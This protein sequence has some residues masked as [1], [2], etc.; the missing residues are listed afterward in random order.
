MDLVNILLVEDLL[1]SDFLS[2]RANP[3]VLVALIVMFTLLATCFEMLVD[4]TNFANW[5][6]VFSQSNGPV[7]IHTIGLSKSIAKEIQRKFISR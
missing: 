6:D 5:L 4:S 7:N 1:E 3:H 2:I